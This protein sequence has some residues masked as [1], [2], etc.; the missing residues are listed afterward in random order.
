VRGIFARRPSS[1]SRSR[2]NCAAPQPDWQAAVNV[3]GHLVGYLHPE[4]YKFLA[5]RRVF[6]PVGRAFREQR[7]FVADQKHVQRG[8]RGFLW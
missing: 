7:P 2:S 5:S 8:S 6:V 3:D 4:R 1:S